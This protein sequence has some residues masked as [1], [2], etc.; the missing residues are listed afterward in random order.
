MTSRQG[1][2]Y[3]KRIILRGTVTSGIGE[4]RF[5]TAI[6]WVREQFQNKLGIDPY[7]GTFNIT[8]IDDHTEELAALRKER[9]I[10]IVPEDSNFCT[11]TSFP[12][13]VNNRVEGMAIIPRVAGYPQTKLEIISAVN[14]RQALSLNERDTVEVEVRPLG[15]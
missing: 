7:P 4:S 14:I 13:L 1:R 6:P 8:V 10:E 2:R 3:S 15:I 11:A 5:F 9:G 12:V